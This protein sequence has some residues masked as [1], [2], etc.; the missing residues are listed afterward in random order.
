VGKI[1]AVESVC[2]ASPGQSGFAEDPK[3]AGIRVHR[4]CFFQAHRLDASV[5]RLQSADTQTKHFHIDVFL[6]VFRS[7]NIAKARAFA[8]ACVPLGTPPTHRKPVG[9]NPPTQIDRSGFQL[10]ARTSIVKRWQSK[11]GNQGFNLR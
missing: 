1:A 7:I 2:R 6:M 10:G 9:T 5:L 11:V 8:L 3:E 4:E